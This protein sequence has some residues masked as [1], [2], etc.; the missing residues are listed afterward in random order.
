MHIYSLRAPGGRLVVALLAVLV[1]VCVRV[2]DA[3]TRFAYTKG[4]VV[5][6][7]YEGWWPNEDGSFTLFFGYFNTNWQEEFDVPIGADNAIEPGGPDHGQPT[8]FYPR[9]NP[10]LFTIRV[11]KEFETTTKELAW[12]LTTNGKTER[13]YATLKGDYRVDPQVIQMEVGGDR[14]SQRHEL[15]TNKPP[16]LKVEGSA[17]RTVRVGE[18]VTLV[19]FAN[20]PDNLPARRERGEEGP[21]GGRERGSSTAKPPEPVDPVKELFRP[22]PNAATPQSPPGLRLSWIVYRGKAAAVTFSPE[23]MKTWEDTRAYA[24][25]PWSPGTVIPPPPPDGKWIVRATFQE[26]GAY[27]LRAVASDSA[28]FTYENVTVTVTR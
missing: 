25:S 13:A 27:V 24:N 26:P 23:Q 22:P 3:Q 1:I 2:G 21:A 16:D 12:T 11:P 4:Q 19:A 5:T 7:T 10:F 9:R 15:R 17:Q 6:P 20:D 18:P 28:L 14:G 8:H